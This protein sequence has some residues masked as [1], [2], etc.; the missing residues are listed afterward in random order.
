MNCHRDYFQITVTYS[1]GGKRQVLSLETKSFPSYDSMLMAWYLKNRNK[2]KKKYLALK[3]AKFIDDI[4]LYIPA[5]FQGS[6]KLHTSPLLENDWYNFTALNFYEQD[7][8]IDQQQ[9]HYKFD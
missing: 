4:V 2:L 7:N 5:K 9:N 3:L 8:F 6:K 1:L